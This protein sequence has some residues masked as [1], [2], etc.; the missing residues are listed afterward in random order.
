LIIEWKNKNLSLDSVIKEAKGK[1]NFF[2]LQL[3]YKN[4]SSNLLEKDK[5]FQSKNVINEEEH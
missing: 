4:Y 2:D 1:M 5:V 3:V